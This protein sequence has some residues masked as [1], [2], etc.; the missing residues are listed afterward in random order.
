MLFG[1]AAKVMPKMLRELTNHVRIAT[2]LAY[3]VGQ[4]AEAT[5]D[6]L[7]EVAGNISSN[8]H[9]PSDNSKRDA[10]TKALRKLSRFNGRGGTRTRTEVAL[11]WILSPERLPIPP[12]SRFEQSAWSEEQR[13]A[14][15]G[16][17]VI[18]YSALL[19]PH[20]LLSASCS[21][22]LAPCSSLRASYS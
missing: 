8:S 13:A 12:L 7:W 5:A 22:L 4:N 20:C 2:T 21:L 3:N 1:L 9:Q 16:A 18:P 15:N 6:A 14:G 19:A 10:N 17:R 11:H